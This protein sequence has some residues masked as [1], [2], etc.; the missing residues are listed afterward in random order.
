MH[1][2]EAGPEHEVA[3]GQDVEEDHQAGRHHSVPAPSV[4]ALSVSDIRLL[5]LCLRLRPSDD[6]D[7]PDTGYWL[8]VY[9]VQCTVYC[10]EAAPVTQSDP[11]QVPAGAWRLSQSGKCNVR[12]LARYNAYNAV[13][14]SVH[15]GNT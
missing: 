13:T 10:T 11:L 8:P 3:R 6:C 4:P 2:P 9:C 14:Y 12:S 15:M 5:C 7:N 1:D